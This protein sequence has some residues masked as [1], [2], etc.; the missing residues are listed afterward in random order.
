M[1]LRALEAELA[2]EQRLVSSLE[3]ALAVC[4]S[5]EPDGRLQQRA[6]AAGGVGEAGASGTPAAQARGD[7]R[8][9]DQVT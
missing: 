9:V 5:H 6:A 8:R 1:A 4:V 2:V 7:A 3:A